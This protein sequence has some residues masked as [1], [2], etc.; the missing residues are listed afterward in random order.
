MA[1]IKM[2]AKERKGIVTVKTLMSHPMETGLRR[3]KKTGKRIPPHYI[4]EV[5][6]TANGNNVMT[7]HW[8]SGIS[9]N[10]YLSFKYTGDKGDTITVSWVDNKGKSETLSGTV[11]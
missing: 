2:R 3:N 10:P 1:N 6:V 11:K 5:T 7:A 8:G 9:K 4:Q